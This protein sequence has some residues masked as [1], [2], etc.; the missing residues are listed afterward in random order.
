MWLD[1][2]LGWKKSVTLLL[3]NR[4]PCQAFILVKSPLLSRLLRS[5]DGMLPQVN[6]ISIVIPPQPQP[7]AKHHN[8]KDPQDDNRTYEFLGHSQRHWRVPPLSL[9]PEGPQ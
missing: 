3:S 2:P 1:Q 5:V 6:A 4:L 9:T 8:L 7:E